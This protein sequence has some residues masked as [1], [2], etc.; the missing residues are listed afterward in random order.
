MVLVRAKLWVRAITTT[1]EQPSPSAQ[2]AYRQN[3][4]EICELMLRI[5]GKLY[6][7]ANDGQQKTWAQVGDQER[8]IEV[9]KDLTE[10]LGT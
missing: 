6:A 2:E 9:L 1:P 10:F 3:Y 7:E 4:G 8:V 5:N